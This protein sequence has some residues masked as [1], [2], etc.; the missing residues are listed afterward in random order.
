MVGLTKCDLL[1]R[2]EGSDSGDSQLISFKELAKVAGQKSFTKLCTTS[3]KHGQDLNV[4]KA[5][6]AALNIAFA[7]KYDVQ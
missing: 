2:A 7:Y 3:A 1:P 5:F 4:H 6:C